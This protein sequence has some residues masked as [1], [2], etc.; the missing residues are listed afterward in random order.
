MHE[1]IAIVIVVAVEVVVVVVIVVVVVVIVDPLQS[2]LT[3][4]S[5][6]HE[7]N[8]RQEVRRQYIF[9]MSQNKQCSK[10]LAY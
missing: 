2:C 4:G 9:Y 3:V 8:V 1:V 5:V 10:S 6:K 7:K